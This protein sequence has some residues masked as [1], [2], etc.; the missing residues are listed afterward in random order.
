MDFIL[1]YNGIVLVYKKYGTN[2]LVERI[3]HP[4]M[5]TFYDIGEKR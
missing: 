5:S 3:Q 2:I 1:G 4:D